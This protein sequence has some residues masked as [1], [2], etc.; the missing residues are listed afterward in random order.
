[1]SNTIIQAL[2]KN[3]IKELVALEERA[4]EVGPYDFEM[5]EHAFLLTNGMAY[6]VMNEQRIAAYIMGVKI[7]ADT[8]D[9]ESI[10]VDP[11][12]RGLGYAKRLI[13]YLE[14]VCKNENIRNLILEVRA[15]NHEAKSLYT[16]MGFRELEYI[17]NYY[18]E[19]HRNTQDAIRMIKLIDQ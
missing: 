12:F 16:K 19:V 7:S 2:Q 15:N 8:V 6:K 5:L 1:M 10:A 3:D 17:K 4:F 9:I 11:D 13:S 14:N 18:N